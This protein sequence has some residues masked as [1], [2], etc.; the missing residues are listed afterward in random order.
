[1]SNTSGLYD[2]LFNYYFSKSRRAAGLGDAQGMSAAAGDRCLLIYVY[3][4]I[5]ELS[6][7]V[8]VYCFY[9]AGS[10]CSIFINFNS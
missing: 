4:C 5:F 2:Y 6:L 10:Y 9:Y 8:D 3:T 1:M 7:Y